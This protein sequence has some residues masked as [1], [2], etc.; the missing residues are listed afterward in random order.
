MPMVYLTE[1]KQTYFVVQTGKVLRNSLYV[2]DIEIKAVI[3]MNI[4]LL[5]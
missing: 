3:A 4:C 2:N 1:K 5:N